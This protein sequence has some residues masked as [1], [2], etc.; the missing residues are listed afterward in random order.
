MI[1]MSQLC[2][3]ESEKTG[4]PQKQEKSTYLIQIHKGTPEIPRKDCWLVAINKGD[5]EFKLEIMK[6]TLRLLIY[7]ITKK[8]Q[9]YFRTL[10]LRDLEKS[11]WNSHCRRFRNRFNWAISTMKREFAVSITVQIIN[12]NI[13]YIKLRTR[14]DYFWKTA[15]AL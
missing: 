12:F 8:F 11:G 3:W 1:L 15:I 5:S 9:C 2:Y 4:L 13:E 6:K 10:K 7:S 14:R